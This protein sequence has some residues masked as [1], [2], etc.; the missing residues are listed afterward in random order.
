M[1]TTHEAVTLRA[2]RDKTPSPRVIWKMMT[3]RVPQDVHR[4]LKIRAAEEAKSIAEVVER[5]IRVYLV[6]G[7][8]H[9]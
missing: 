4:A 1:N 6:K 7:D 5:L 3:I 9:A 8:R 2:K